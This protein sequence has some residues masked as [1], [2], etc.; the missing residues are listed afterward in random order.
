L[1]K[2][3]ATARS[4]RRRASLLTGRP[5]TPSA[6]LR[7]NIPAAP[8]RVR[9]QPWDGLPERRR[10]EIVDTE[11]EHGAAIGVASAKGAA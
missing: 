4:D 9:G 5:Y 7:A 11:C 2:T 1:L 8:I 6:A 3:T 10:E